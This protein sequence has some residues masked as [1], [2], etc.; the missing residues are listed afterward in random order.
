MLDAWFLLDAMNGIGP[1]EVRAAGKFLQLGMGVRLPSRRR[2][3]TAALA[4]ALLALLLSA[5]AYAQGWFGLSGWVTASED[6]SP[7]AP[8]EESVGTRGYM[9]SNGYAD[10]PESLAGAEWRQYYWEHADEALKHDSPD[11]PNDM[12]EYAQT[13]MIY[14]VFD[15]EMLDALLSIRDRYGLAIHTAF[16]HL[17]SENAHFTEDTGVGSFLPRQDLGDSWSCFY[18]FEDGSFKGEGSLYL[19]GKEFGY[20]LERYKSGTVDPYAFFIQDT[21]NYEEWKL[22]LDGR[23]L[24]LALEPDADWP[25]GFI[26]FNS[27]DMYV[28]IRIYSE[29][30]KAEDGRPLFQDLSRETL[31][32]LAPRFNYGELTGESNNSN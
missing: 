29:V 5:F 26:L 32:A 4:A 27:G 30:L 25:S 16:L 22:E 23:T 15:Q 7:Y 20:A 9:V 2:L 17:G 19:D 28:T 14:G 24:Y 21:A 31:E 12:G 6:S 10:S 8:Q 3:W 1:E 13:A 18:I 11:W